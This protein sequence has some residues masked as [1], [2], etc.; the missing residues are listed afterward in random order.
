MP[1]G[2]SAI[3][4]TYKI[5]IIINDIK[6]WKVSRKLSLTNEGLVIVY[7]FYFDA[8]KGRYND[9]TSVCLT[10]NSFDQRKTRQ[11][12]YFLISSFFSNERFLRQNLWIY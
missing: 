4:T 6:S 10:Q 3:T 5:R 2:K 8:K 9:L 7:C 12:S 11:I 1:A